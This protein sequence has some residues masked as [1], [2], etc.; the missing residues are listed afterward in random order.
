MKIAEKDISDSYIIFLVPSLLV[1]LAWAIEIGSCLA[2]GI[3][4]NFMRPSSF[5]IIS[6]IL[7]SLPIILI[8]IP[9]RQKA[10]K[11]TTRKKRSTWYVVRKVLL[12]VLILIMF[13][14]EVYL[15]FIKGLI[16]TK[17]LIIMVLAFSTA[18]AVKQLESQKGKKFVKSM[19]IFKELEADTAKMVEQIVRSAA[20]YV[21]VLVFCGSMGFVASLREGSDDLRET[22]FI[23][24]GRE[25]VVVKVYGD[26]IYAKEYNPKDQRLR[27]GFWVLDGTNQYYQAKEFVY[28]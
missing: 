23:K 17:V 21:V 1:G 20:Y 8:L 26:T 4:G 14:L 16:P 28:R 9:S 2:L 25:L 6:A 10:K 15:I 3:D 24:D 5:G 7:I 11:K 12:A 27:S 13:G 19:K 18:I 22:Y